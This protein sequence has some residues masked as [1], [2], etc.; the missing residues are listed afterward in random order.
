MLCRVFLFALR[1]CCLILYI[2]SC[3]KWKRHITLQAKGAAD[4]SQQ[5]HLHKPVQVE[6][7]VFCF[8]LHRTFPVLLLLLQSMQLSELAVCLLQV[9]FQEAGTSIYHSFQH[10]A[11]KEK[12][13]FDSF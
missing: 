11:V 2:V 13:F 7:L 10:K 1:Y 3:S 5:N 9:C 12:V 4:C 8:D 6:V